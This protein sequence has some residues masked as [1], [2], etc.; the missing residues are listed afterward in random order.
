MENVVAFELA[1]VLEEF[2]SN[3]IDQLKEQIE[4]QRQINIEY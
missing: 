4:A 2:H 3:H 1:K